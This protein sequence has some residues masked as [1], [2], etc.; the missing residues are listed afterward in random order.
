MTIRF[1]PPARYLLPRP[2]VTERISQWWPLLVGLSAL[3]GL[4]V[5]MPGR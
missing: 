1:A 2:L 4:M 3:L 5:S